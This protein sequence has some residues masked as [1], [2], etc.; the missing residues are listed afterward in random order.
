MYIHV[1]VYIYINALVYDIYLYTIYIGIYIVCIIYYVY[2][3]IG[4]HPK[5][6]KGAGESLKNN[7]SENYDRCNGMRRGE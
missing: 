2:M 7:K 5:R 6:C 3:R 4:F 1:C